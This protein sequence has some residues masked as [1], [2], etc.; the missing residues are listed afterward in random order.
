MAEH[1]PSMYKAQES[2]S[3]TIDNR[4]EERAP[5]IMYRMMLI[6]ISLAAGTSQMLQHMYLVKIVQPSRSINE[7]HHSKRGGALFNATELT[8]R[9]LSISPVWRLEGYVSNG[10]KL[11]SSCNHPWPVKSQALQTH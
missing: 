8:W 3:S 5:Q 1:L 11:R 2:I 4:N 7:K 6:I 10:D 9:S